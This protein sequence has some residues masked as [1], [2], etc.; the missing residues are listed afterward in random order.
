MDMISEEQ[1]AEW[2]QARLAGV[3]ASEMGA[4]LGLD[5]SRSAFSLWAEK[6]GRIPPADLS[7]SREI[8]WGN[9]IEPVLA[10]VYAQKSGRRLIDHGRTAIRR[11]AHPVLFATLDREI[12][13][14][15]D[16]RGAGVYEG[17]NAD[18]H[19]TGEWND[20]PPLK[21]VVQVQTQLLVTGLRWGV[22][23]VLLG[24]NDDRFIEIERNDALI[25]VIDSAA[26]EF[27][28]CVTNDVPPEVDG[29]QATR[30][31]IKKLYPEDS[32]RTVEL[33][34]T[35]ATQA[36]EDLIRAK[37]ERKKWEDA[38]RLA[39]NRIRALAGDATFLK[40]GGRELT[41]KTVKK[42]AYTVEPQS[43]RMLLVKKEKATKR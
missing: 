6:T 25:D 40:I 31:A 20:A 11:G 13:D 9:Q 3:G 18:D 12:V 5:R 29:S 30:E 19:L 10:A 27:W 32:G 16:G 14:N 2:L 24:G 26:R 4:I 43:Y 37:A 38:E 36:L 15:G 7:S 23:G 42:A 22:L 1:R 21:H 34:E 41:L 8:F 39:D 33:V 35:E 17:K 28:Q